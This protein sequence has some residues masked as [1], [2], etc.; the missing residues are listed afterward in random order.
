MDRAY[1][2]VF[3][4]FFLSFDLFNSVGLNL[5]HRI[6]DHISLSV[7]PSAERVISLCYQT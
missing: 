2:M 6:H 3:L 7:C 5:P 4:D 1:F